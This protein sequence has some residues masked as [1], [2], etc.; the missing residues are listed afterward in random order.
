M[1][2]R[3]YEKKYSTYVLLGILIEVKMKQKKNKK[4]YYFIFTRDPT[5][6]IPTKAFM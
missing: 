4:R 2:K 5:I 3:N 6:K 1:V